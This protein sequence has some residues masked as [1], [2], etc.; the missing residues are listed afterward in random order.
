VPWGVSVA[1][2]HGAGAIS[3]PISLVLFAVLP[4][5]CLQGSRVVKNV[6]FEG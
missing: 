3:L 6:Y 4:L 1:W 2:T 5:L